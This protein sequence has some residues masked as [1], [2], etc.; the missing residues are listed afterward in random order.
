M[1]GLRQA[2]QR[3]EL[4]THPQSMSEDGKTPGAG[5][6]SPRNIGEPDKSVGIMLRAHECLKRWAARY[7]ESDHAKKH[8]AKT[9]ARFLIDDDYEHQRMMILE[10]KV[11]GSVGE[12]TQKTMISFLNQVTGTIN[13]RGQ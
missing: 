3:S 1:L 12:D 5:A 11:K 13:G 7:A 2:D 4:P 8:V 9:R 6:P 10:I